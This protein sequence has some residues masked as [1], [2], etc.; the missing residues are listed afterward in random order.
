MSNGTL[1][2][3]KPAGSVLATIME[4]A[5]TRLVDALPAHL[6]PSRM[7]ALV[8]VLA[9]RNPKILECVPESIIT[10]LIQVGTLDLDLT[11]G[12]N[13]AHL[14]PRW[15]KDVVVNGAKGAR[16]C[17]FMPGYKGLEKLAVRTGVVMYVDPCEVRKGD[18]FRVWR[19]DGEMHIEHEPAYQT[20]RGEIEYVYTVAHMFDGKVTIEVMNADEV[21]EIHSRSEGARSARNKNERETGPWVSDWKEMALKTVIKRHCK[22]FPR[23]SDPVKAKAFDQLQTAIEADNVQYQ[24]ALP[25]DSHHAKN[26]DNATGHGSGAY[27]APEVVADYKEWARAFLA[28]WQ[29]KWCD[30][31]SKYEGADA[32]PRTREL[33]SPWQ[34]TGHLFKFARERQLFNAPPDAKQG[35]KPGFLAVAWERNREVLIAEAA[36][37][38]AAVWAEKRAILEPEEEDAPDADYSQVD[39]QL[40]Q[41]E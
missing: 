6:T 41:S 36:E 18:K 37:Y 23:P 34:L 10:S 28:D 19:V 20:G 26:F 8:S 3:R 7:S 15:N 38:T 31:A 2:K 35:Q 11:P 9:Y 22:R 17:T 16:E 39:G 1:A 24:D 4:Q 30:F 5:S 14:I 29:A 13:E 21:E 32:D 27:A 12:M 33:L 25:N 40:G